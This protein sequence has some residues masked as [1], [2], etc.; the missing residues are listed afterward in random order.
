MHSQ[1][2]NTL[3]LPQ[4]ITICV[5]VRVQLQPFT[6]IPIPQGR[7]RTGHEDCFTEDGRFEDIKRDGYTANI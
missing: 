6:R 4:W 7:M 3:D 1:Y 2:D 5:S